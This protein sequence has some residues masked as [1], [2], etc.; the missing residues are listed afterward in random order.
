VARP[1]FCFEDF[2]R[3]GPLGARRIR[4]E[5]WGPLLRAIGRRFRQQPRSFLLPPR[6][7]PAGNNGG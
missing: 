7:A 4:F 6:T 2:L 3:C 5:H 1:E